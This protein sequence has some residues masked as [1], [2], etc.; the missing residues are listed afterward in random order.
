[1]SIIAMTKYWGVIKMK[2]CP[3]CRQSKEDSEFSK[4]RSRRNGLSDWC[5]KCERKRVRKYQD[6]KRGG[7]P[8]KKHYK[9]EQTHRVVYEVK[10]KR[11]RK[12][13]KWKAESEFHRHRRNKNGLDFR[14]R[15]CARKA[16]M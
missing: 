10:Q 9:Y 2:K 6:E 11:C 8:S 15:A 7:K 3:K 13:M 4:N 14:C 16:R 12:C 5:K 1:L